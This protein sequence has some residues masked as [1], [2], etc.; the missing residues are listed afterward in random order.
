MMSDRDDWPI[1]CVVL[2]DG[3]SFTVTPTADAVPRDEINVMQHYTGSVR[4]VR[5]DQCALH[6][7]V[8]KE[9][10]EQL[11]KSSMEQAFAAA[12]VKFDE[13]L[14]GYAKIL[15]AGAELAPNGPNSPGMLFAAELLRK[16]VATK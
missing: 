13:E 5:M 2:I 4:T 6:E 14:V 1:G 16:A 10:I 8:T 9:T 3:T 11:V 12:R 15:E 7:P